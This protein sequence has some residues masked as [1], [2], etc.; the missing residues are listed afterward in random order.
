MSELTRLLKQLGQDAK[1]HD[2]YLADPEAVM[3]KR[4]LDKAEIQA[5]LDKDVDRL[6]KLSGLEDLKSNSTVKACS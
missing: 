1:L 3:R 5:M 2:Q 6:R 4:G